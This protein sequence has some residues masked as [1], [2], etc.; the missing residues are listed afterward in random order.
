LISNVFPFDG[1]YVGRLFVNCTGKPSEILTR[2]NNLAGFDPDE[3][4]ELYE[5]G[6]SCLIFLFI[7]G[8][9]S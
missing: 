1:S 4:I 6:I 2:L 8:A 9:T 5:V 7:C 3:E